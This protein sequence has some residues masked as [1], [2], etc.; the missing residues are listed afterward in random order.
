[1]MLEH[2]ETEILSH[3]ELAEVRYYSL[4][5]LG[6]KR[7]RGLDNAELCAEHMEIAS[8]LIEEAETR[9]GKNSILNGYRDRLNYLREKD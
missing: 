7:F 6:I 9:W 8:R 1:M 4:K 2:K 5:H 3:V